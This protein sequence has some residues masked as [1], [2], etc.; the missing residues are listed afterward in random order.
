[1]SS[2]AGGIKAGSRVDRRAKPRWK[3]VL[4][5]TF[6]W[7][8]CVFSVFAIVGSIV[9]VPHLNKAKGMIR[10]LPTIMEQ[11]SSQPSEIDSDD[12]AVLYSLQEQFRRPITIDD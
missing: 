2:V 9:F 1:M 3:R 6:W 8:V 11:I 5:K 4:I 12:G 10:N 7:S